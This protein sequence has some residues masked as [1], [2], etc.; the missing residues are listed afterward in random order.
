MVAAEPLGD[1]GGGGAAEAGGSR[2]SR[3]SARPRRKPAEN[4]SPQPVVSTTSTAKAGTALDRITVDHDAPS[5]PQV[6]ATQ[7]T[8][9]SI[10]ARQPA[11]RSVSPV[12]PRTCSSFGS[13]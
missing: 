4:A 5:A 13:R 11:T 1:E 12:K 10:S 2:R 7:P 8:P 3:P 6:A 9:R